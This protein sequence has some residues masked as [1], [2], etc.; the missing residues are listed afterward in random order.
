MK[1]LLFPTIISPS[2]FDANPA[3]HIAKQDFSAA[4]AD[5]NRCIDFA[6]QWCKVRLNWEFFLEAL[7]VKMGTGGSSI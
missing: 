6:P 3:A 7:V 1:I 5:A 4:L 2:R